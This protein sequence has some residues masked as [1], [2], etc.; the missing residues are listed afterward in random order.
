MG[1]GYTSSHSHHLIPLH[2]EAI[3][4]VILVPLLHLLVP[5][6]WISSHHHGN[7][8]HPPKKIVIAVTATAIK[9][10]MSIIMSNPS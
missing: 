5:T 9:L 2:H 1:Q 8:A 10:L 6:L 4:T 7:N 3:I